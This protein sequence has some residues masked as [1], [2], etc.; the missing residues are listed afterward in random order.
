MIHPRQRNLTPSYAQRNFSDQL[1]YI[2]QWQLLISPDAHHDRLQI[3]QEAYLALGEFQS[4]DK[5]FN[6]T[7][8]N[9][10]HGIFIMVISGQ[11]NLAEHILH[12]RDAIMLSGCAEINFTV[13][14]STRLLLIEV[15]LTITL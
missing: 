5:V 14:H 9:S 4:P 6:Y 1:S 13:N 2:D 12:N 15:P 10:T 11:L 8:H 7:L 3:N